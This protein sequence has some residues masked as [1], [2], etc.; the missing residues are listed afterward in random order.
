MNAWTLLR[1]FLARFEA[2]ETASQR[3]KRLLKANL[4]PT[5]RTQYDKFRYFEVIGGETGHRYRI[6]RSAALNVDEYDDAGTRISR[7]CFLPVG[8]IVDADVLLAQKLALELFESHAR[9]V[10]NKCSAH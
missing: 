10:A 4:T 9:A 6:H 1:A 3:A 5:Q 2:R 7:W 8:D